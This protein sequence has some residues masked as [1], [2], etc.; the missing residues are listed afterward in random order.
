[1]IFVFQVKNMFLFPHA[2][3]LPRHEPLL[4]LAPHPRP[5]D[6]KRGVGGLRVGQHLAGVRAR[7][8]GPVRGG[9]QGEEQSQVV[10]GPSER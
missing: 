9:Q 10:K 2:D 5:S 6:G 7:I 3:A 4:L 8:E 1:M